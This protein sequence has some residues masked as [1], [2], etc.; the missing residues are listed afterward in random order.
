[1]IAG[2]RNGS[3]RAGNTG[4]FDSR[5]PEHDEHLTSLPLHERRAATPQRTAMTKRPSTRKAGRK[6]VAK[7]AKKPARKPAA[8]K[9]AA[10]RVKAAEP[11]EMPAATKRGRPTA[12]TDEI[13]DEICARLAEGQTLSSICRRE[14]MPSERTVR[15][16]ALD[17]G[18]AFSPRY[19][20]ARE[21][22]YHKMA[23]DLL[24]IVDDGTNDF[25]VRERDG[26]QVTV[27]DHEHIQRSR[28][29]A[30]TR[31]WLLSKA[32][33]KLYGDKVDVAHSG[34]VEPEQSPEQRELT[35][36][37]LAR[38]VAWMLHQAVETKKRLEGGTGPSGAEQW[39]TL[40]RNA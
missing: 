22:G 4:P 5:A 19:A 39:P 3:S 6:P 26:G 33:P 23:D 27:V 28:L 34:T 16:W 38:R 36:L 29:R 20:R 9:P 12:Y 21:V 18:H 15:T 32:L 2:K 7:P 40:I 10:P 30:E 11:I 25:V 31:K 13:A 14:G 8:K 37:D 35:N 24:D 1:M 17:P